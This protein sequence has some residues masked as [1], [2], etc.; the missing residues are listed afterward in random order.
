MRKLLKFIVRKV[1]RIYL[2]KFSYAFS[3][4]FAAFY[5]GNKQHCPICDGNFRT[6]LP[7]GYTDNNAENRLCPSCLSLERHRLI[8]LY[9]KNE[10][11]LFTEPMNMLHIAPEQSFYKRF[12]A[13]KTL[14]YF[15][16]D[17][18]SP[19]AEYH[20]DIHE[21]PFED[22]KFDF[23]MCNH[24]LEHVDDEFKVTRELYRVLKPGGFAILQVPINLDFN[25]TYED[26]S[27]TTAK[28]REKH[29]GQY[30]HVRWHGLDYP[31]RLEKSGFVVDSLGYIGKFT[32]EEVEKMRLP[33]SELLYIARKLK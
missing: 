7:Y 14:D 5:K 10:T 6:F 26:K 8:W 22:N 4:I 12:K 9:L 27:I 28:E 19:L 20:F 3:W 24:V 16:A 21:I 11:K 18:E 17:L 15:T 1:P 30:D 2:I 33:K 31:E 32:D 25:K 23:I 13:I 29:Y